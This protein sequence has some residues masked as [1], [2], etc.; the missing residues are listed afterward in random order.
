MF[1]DSENLD[2]IKQHSESDYS[3]H[4]WVGGS[5][6][7]N[8]RYDDA[9][10][11]TKSKCPA[12]SGMNCADVDNAL[13]CIKNRLSGVYGWSTS[14]KKHRRVRDR[15]IKA[16]KSWRDTIQGWY[17]AGNCDAVVNVSVGGC[18]DREATN[19]DNDATYDDG[20]CQ[21]SPEVVYGCTDSSAMN[22]D[23]FA[24]ND[25]NSCQFEKPSSRVYGCMSKKAE[26]YNSK[27]THP[28]GSC[29]FD[30]DK[31]K[32]DFKN[33]L[34]IIDLSDDI[35]NLGTTTSGVGDTDES[36]NNMMMYGVI[37]VAALA[38][39]IILLKK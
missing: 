14:K 34:G 33:D 24:T 2:Y 17:N 22:Y 26:N 30:K 21:F 31:I 20:S 6:A 25:D 38:T 18:M 11:D 37:G 23:G 16:C 10:N 5:H 8:H 12:N 19:Y 36:N 9:Y 39:I 1:I 27:A 7:E 28:D 29:E 35:A 4:T 3:N 15:H 13:T 32:E